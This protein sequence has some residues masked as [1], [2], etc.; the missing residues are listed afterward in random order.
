MR[1]T[2][3]W[4]R[5]PQRFAPEIPDPG[6]FGANPF[7]FPLEPEQVQFPEVLPNCRLLGYSRAPYNGRIAEA[8]RAG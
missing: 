4:R 7:R 1:W 3:L 8:L 2:V 6:I 5:R